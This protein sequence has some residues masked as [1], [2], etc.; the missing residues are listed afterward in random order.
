MFLL[1]LLRASQLF[2]TGNLLSPVC[3]L[4]ATVQGKRR[5]RH[6]LLNNRSYHGCAEVFDDVKQ[7]NFPKHLINLLVPELFF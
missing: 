4:T 2:G 3:T 1:S 7:Y 5:K 6:T